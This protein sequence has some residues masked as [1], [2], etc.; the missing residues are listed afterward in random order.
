MQN[1]LPCHRSKE[2]YAASQKNSP[3]AFFHV[4]LKHIYLTFKVPPSTIIKQSKPQCFTATSSSSSSVW[5]SCRKAH[6][7]TALQKRQDFPSSTQTSNWL[8]PQA[9][10]W[11]TCVQSV[12]TVWLV[13]WEVFSSGPTFSFRE[14]AQKPSIKMLNSKKSW[15]LHWHKPYS[16]QVSLFI[17][18]FSPQ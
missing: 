14:L 17:C 10:V 4:H 16:L 9:G 13:P 8:E 5:V 1:T 11:N 7:F 6:M 3:L 2:H 15:L 18:P 12:W